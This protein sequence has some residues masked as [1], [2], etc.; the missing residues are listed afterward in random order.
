VG[1]GRPTAVLPR[2]RSFGVVSLPMSRRRNLAA[3]FTAAV[4]LAV[5]PSSSSA[6]AG[7]VGA[8]RAAGLHILRA[9]AG[10]TAGSL[11]ALVV[12]DQFGTDDDP[13]A[14]LQIDPG[15]RRF[16][17]RFNIRPGRLSTMGTLDLAA[18]IRSSRGGWWRLQVRDRVAGEWVTVH[19]SGDQPR[20]RWVWRAHGLDPSRVLDGGARLQVRVVGGGAPVSLDLLVSHRTVWQP[21][22]GTTWQ[23][24]LTGDIDTSF[25]VAMYDIDLFDTAGPAI[26][27]LHAGGMAVVCY[28]SAGAWEDWR[29]DAGD[30]PAVVLGDDNGWEGERW[31]DIRRLDLLRPIMAARLDLAAAKGCDGVEPDNVDGY[32]NT[33]GFPLSGTDQLA[34]NTWLAGAAHR[35]GL[36]IGLKNDLDQIPALAGYFDWALDEQC[37]QYDECDLLRPFVDADKAVFGVEYRGK[38]GDFCPEARSM[39]FSWLLKRLD[40]GSWVEAC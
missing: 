27:D 4:L 32:A 20:N 37:F 22:P 9:V 12:R 14:Y 33:T 34:F 23:W 16:D 2:L 7:T 35:R 24:Q 13:A 15:D 39:G 3:T 40:L 29:P 21:E 6:N 11:D 31:L 10:T 26:D 19:G 30:F 28:F 1:G 25:D 38:T 36:S 5:V 17:V 18:A 8:I